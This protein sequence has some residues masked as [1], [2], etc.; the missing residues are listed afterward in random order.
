MDPNP[1]SLQDA[2]NRFSAVV[3]AAM[4]GAAQFVTKRGRAAVVVVSATEYQRLQ[5]VEKGQAT[6]LAE[7]LLAMPQDDQEFE[8]IPLTPR[9]TTL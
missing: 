3:E 2:K 8:R 6:S 5:S 4:S 1:W 9:D 7:H